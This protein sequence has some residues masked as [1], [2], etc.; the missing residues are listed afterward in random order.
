M[1]T[2][3]TEDTATPAPFSVHDEASAAWAADKI[4]SARERL[5]RV[6]AACAEMIA[7]A[8]REVADL[9]GLFLP[10]LEEWA[11]QNPPRKG[12]TIRLPTGA[13]AFRTVP[14]GPR[15]ADEEAALSWARQHLP[16]AVQVRE[17]V[18]AAEIKGYVAATGE[19]PPGVELAEERE[20]FSVKGA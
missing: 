7:E 10:Q 13:L 16:A 2:T 5:A 11:R 3:T 14:G 8:G 9:E 4:L 6:T 1:S 15:V 12:K 18:I 17:R 20:T 19:L